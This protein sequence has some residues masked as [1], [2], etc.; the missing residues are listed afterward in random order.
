M[1]PFA[2]IILGGLGGVLVACLLLGKF[3]P[4]DG[5]D[6]LKW[7]PTRSPEVEAQN[8]IDDIDQMLEAANRRRRRRGDAELTE[9]SMRERVA[10]DTAKRHAAADAYA[11]EQGKHS[12]ADDEIAQ[13][14]A[15]KNRRRKAKGLEPITSEEFRR[16]L[17]GGV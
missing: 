9:E 16:D 13:V 4:G 8:E 12:A 5:R 14:L 11:V 6:V 17:E 1:D 7:E 2:V 10:S 3:Y 15:V